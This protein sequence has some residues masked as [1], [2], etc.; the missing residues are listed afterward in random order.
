MSAIVFVIALYSV[1]V[2]LASSSKAICPGNTTSD[3]ILDGIDLKGK[4]AVVTGGDSGLGFA[5]AMGFAKRGATVIIATH[6]YSKGVKAA[7]E[8]ARETGADVSAPW[9]LDLSSLASVR[10]FSKSFL[11]KFTNL[12]LLINNAG[13]GHPSI[14]SSDKFELV[15]EVDY[16]GHFL[17]TELLLPTLRQSSPSRIVNVA[18]GAHENA[19]ESAGW[20]EGCFKDFTYLP[21]PI[22]PVKNVTV[23]YRTGARVTRSSSYGIAKFAQTQ[24]AAELAIREKD[25]GVQ[26][27]AITPGF[28]LTSMTSGVDPKKVM[29]ST[30]CEEQTHPAPYLPAQPCPFSAAQG[31][32]VIAY[33]ATG[34]AKNGRY[35]SRG[36]AC[37]ERAVVQ[38]GMSKEVRSEFY[39]R[40]KEWVGIKGSTA[41]VV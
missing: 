19:C 32:A 41:V 9:T 11:A 29:N 15:F 17:L 2:D 12:H 36:F 5:T 37:E 6:N 34:D 16:L 8:I 31:A 10:S 14:L 20:P 25:S 23:H 3:D 39:M 24:H 4:I 26:A 13:I 21:P 28:A 35:Y 1:C 38:H 33:V 7:S 30:F 40:S 18:S 27:F 22:V